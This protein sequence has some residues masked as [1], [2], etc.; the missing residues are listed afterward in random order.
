LIE[1]RK[2][3]KS[4]KE[5]GMKGRYIKRE[6]VCVCVCVCVCVKDSKRGRACVYVL[7]KDS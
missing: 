2:D 6:I 1:V 4:E 7:V 3:N 5:T